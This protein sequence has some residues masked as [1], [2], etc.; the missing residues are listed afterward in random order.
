MLQGASLF[1][2]R[3]KE[4]VEFSYSLIFGHY[5]L[6]D[7]PFTGVPQHYT[8]TWIQI[9]K[10]SAGRDLSNLA[11][12]ILIILPY[13]KVSSLPDCILLARPAI[14]HSPSS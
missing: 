4:S 2:E 10:G 5:F 14:N 3:N 1:I 8:V 12:K 11:Y 6:Y 13:C 7:T 9:L